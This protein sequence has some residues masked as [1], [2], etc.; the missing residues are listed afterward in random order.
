MK[1]GKLIFPA[2]WLISMVTFYPT[3][4][5]GF[6]FDFLG[7]QRQ[8]D[9]GSFADILTSFGYKGNHQVLHFFFYSIYCLFHTRGLP[10][11]VLFCSLH[12]F[13]AWLLY[14]WLTDVSRRWKVQ[15]PALLILLTSIVFVIHP[16]NV[17]P[18]VWKVCVHYLLS[19]S[20]VLALLLW[21]GQ[22]L[23]NG[24]KWFLWAGF[25]VYALS[26]FLLE[27]SYVTP[28]VITLYVLIHHF[29][30][31]EHKPELKR[32]LLLPAGLWGLL[33]AGLLI[34]RLTLGAW[35]GHYGSAAHLK[36]DVIG[37]MST[38]IKYLVSHLTDARYFS[39]KIKSVLFDTVLSNPELIFFILTAIIGIII[40]Y[41]IRFKK[42]GP[43]IHLAFFGV[44]ASMLYTLTISNLFFYHLMIGTNDRFSYLPLTFLLVAVAALFSKL[45]RWL[46]IGLLSG[47][48]LIQAYLQEKTIR[49]WKQSTEIVDH[50]RDTF[51]WHDRS[52]VFVLNSPDNYNG[53]VMTRIIE[54]PSGIDELIDFQT[55][56]PYDG[57]MFDVYQYNMTTPLDG[58]KVEQTGPMQLKVTFNQWGNWWHR[59]GIGASAYEND[60]YKA[61]TL[62]YPYLITFKQLPPNS[63]IIYQDGEEWQEFKMKIE[64]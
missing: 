6:V 9:Q 5:A 13:N 23:D 44:S 24:R 21:T 61:E 31:A 20:A 47:I 10:W 26:L 58:V 22:Y 53:I 28:A 4:G 11:Y 49:Y 59:N 54:A 12:A 30:G 36:L 42:V 45:P 15:L 33:V 57:Q 2:L 17:E 32:A 62:D 41:V 1:S 34:N 14:H 3:I 43:H 38:E 63:A 19:L 64:E 7:W 40:L 46:W 25:G 37:M 48:L 60:F 39:F 18:V 55:P 52:H 50:L 29:A 35:V 56:K 16:Y 51:R 8:Y 27:L